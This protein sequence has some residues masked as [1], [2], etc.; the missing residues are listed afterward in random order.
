MGPLAYYRR[1]TG[2]AADA[3]PLDR[4]PQQDPARALAVVAGQ[5]AP[6]LARRS[7]F[8]SRMPV[9]P[10]ITPTPEPVGERGGL[11]LLGLLLGRRDLGRLPALRAGVHDRSR[12]IP[13]QRTPERMRGLVAV[14]LRRYLLFGRRRRVRVAERSMSPWC[15]AAY[16]SVLNAEQLALLNQAIAQM[17]P[18]VYETSPANESARAAFHELSK[19]A[20]TFFGPPY[21][22]EIFTLNGTIPHLPSHHRAISAN[23]PHPR[24]SRVCAT[25]R[26]GSKVSWARTSPAKSS[27]GFASSHRRMVSHFA[28]SYLSQ[29][30]WS[31]RTISTTS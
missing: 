6:S 10:D 30:S 26:L 2:Q 24:Y 13:V 25:Y 3:P 12:R 1:P 19:R 28:A 9:E 21:L 18:A 14:F 7:L 22:A 31:A 15:R 11:Q 4:G 27:S 20:Q 23:T 17:S 16:R 29:P 5:V 8:P